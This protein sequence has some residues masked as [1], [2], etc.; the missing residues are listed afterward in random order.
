LKSFTSYDIHDVRLLLAVFP[1]VATPP[2][3]RPPCHPLS[4]PLAS[5]FESLS[6]KKAIENVKAKE[7]IEQRGENRRGKSERGR[8]YHK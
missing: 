3:L 7:Q 4:L 1:R 5:G 8:I 6:I 2:S